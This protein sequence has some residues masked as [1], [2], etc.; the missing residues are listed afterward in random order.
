MKSFGKREIFAVEYEILGMEDGCFEMWVYNTPV[1]CSFKNN[2]VKQYRWDLSYIVEWLDDNISNILK[3][4]EFPLPV[5]Y[6]PPKG[7]GLL[8]NGSPD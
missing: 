7:G 8:L 1:C 2:I 3:E 5:N 4:D 6:P